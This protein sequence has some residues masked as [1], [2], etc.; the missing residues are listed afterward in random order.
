MPI[1][2]KT[3]SVF[4]MTE[5]AK[6]QKKKIA[7]AADDSPFDMA[8]WEASVALVHTWLADHQKVLT[9]DEI[10]GYIECCAASVAAA[11]RYENLEDTTA[12]MLQKHGCTSAR[13]TTE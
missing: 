4:S 6:E 7:A 8:D 11:A 10:I 5:G 12:E 13:R 2:A 9:I 1:Q 3:A